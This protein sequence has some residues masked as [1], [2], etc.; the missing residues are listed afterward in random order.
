MTLTIDVQQDTDALTTT[1]TA[2]F[3]A[4]VDAVWQVWADP[5]K[6]ERWW[7][8]P[9]HPATVTAHSLEQGATVTYFMTGPEGDKHGGLFKILEA[10][11]PNRLRFKDAF[12]DAEGNVIDDMPSTSAIVTLVASGNGTVMTIES[13]FSTREDMD[14][15]LAMGMLDGIQQAIGQIPAILGE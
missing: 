10:D 7:G 5:R 13:Q 11:P 8:P 14:K 1:L 9:T 6:L 3:D 15:L 4:P 2:E 12:C